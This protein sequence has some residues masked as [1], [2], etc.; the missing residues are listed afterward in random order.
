MKT[1]EE[2]FCA[3]HRCTEQEFSRRIFW[4]CLHRHAVPVAPLILALHPRYFTAERELI[5]Q[6]RRAE[7]MTDVWEQRTD[8]KGKIKPFNILKNDRIW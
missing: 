1:F 6:I 3:A 4:K 8:K 7:K 5:G 2:K